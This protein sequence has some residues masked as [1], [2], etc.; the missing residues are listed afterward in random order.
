[1]RR[2]PLFAMPGLIAVATFP[3]AVA[4]QDGIDLAT[5]LNA[6]ESKKK[7][8]LLATARQLG[9][10]GTAGK[11][12]VP[13]LAKLLHEH[14]D[15]AVSSQ[16]AVALVQIGWPAVDELVQ[17]IRHGSPTVQERALL[18]MQRMGPQARGA[19]AE[20]REII[21]ERPSIL[22]IQVLGEMGSAAEPAVAELCQTLR[23]RK[24]HHPVAAALPR[25]KNLLQEAAALALRGLGSAA[26]PGIRD[27]LRDDLPD[28]RL[29]GLDALA[30]L[31]PEGDGAV[32]DVAR[33]LRDRDPLLRVK[34]A[35]TLG[36]VG[37][38]AR[39][40]IPSLL[41]NMKDRNVEVQEASFQALLQVGSQDVPGLMDAFRKLN[42]EE[43]W[44]APIPLKQFGPAMRDA[45]K[46]L[47]LDLQGP[48][49]G[50]RLGAALALGEIGAREATFALQKALRDASPLVRQSAAASLAQIL[51]ESQKEIWRKQQQEAASR[52][53]EQRLA[54]ALKQLPPAAVALKGGAGRMIGF[55]RLDRQALFNPRVQASYNQ[56]I[57][58]HIITSAKFKTARPEVL[59]TTIEQFGPEAV[60]ALIRGMHISAQYNL[61]FC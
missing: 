34:A 7:E 11:E 45:V 31:G 32:A 22:A 58:L 37:P 18:A 43:R 27:L 16:A 6:L 30:M 17:A 14:S 8:V 28:V 61:G 12:A 15:P 9:S 33:L 29:A 26:V 20:L 5:H 2:F 53:I 60:P 25:R 21:R 39:E 10:Y 52:L 24:I 1:M 48:N 44:A 19:V 40:A 57:D 41:A 13:A 46:P 47:I 42:D 36:G 51:G 54:L 49:E 56:I 35:E 4:A 55:S 3:L 50:K 23:G 38:P 59:R